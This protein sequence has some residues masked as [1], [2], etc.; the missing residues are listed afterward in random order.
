[1]GGGGGFFSDPIQSI[2]D[3]IQQDIINPVSDALSSVDHAVNNIIP[4]GWATVGAAALMAYGIYDPEL[5]TSAEEGTLT[6]TELSDAG[7][8]AETVAN[9]V[10]QA[11]QDAGFS[12]TAEY[13]TALSNGFTNATEYANATSA[14]FTNASEYA[15]ATLNGFTNA[16]EYN[17]ATTAGFT[18]AGTFQ[19]AQGLGYSTAA[20]YTAGQAGGFANAAE[21]TT[22]T[23]QGFTD[24][25]TYNT[26]NSLGYTSA[27]E[28]AAG[29]AGGFENAAQYTEAT[30]HGFNTLE[31]YQQAATNAGFSNTATYNTAL[32]AGFTDAPTYETA[33]NL[34]Y[35]TASDYS[36]GQLG[37]YANAN[38]WTTA[39]NLGYADNAQYQ[40]GLKGGFANADEMMTAMTNAGFSDPVTFGNAIDAGFTPGAGATAA[41]YLTSLQ[42]GL[43]DYG[44]YAAAVAA[45][46]IIPGLLH[47]VQPGTTGGGYAGE[48]AWQWGSA[49]ATNYPG[50]NPGLLEGQVTP[51]YTNNTSPDQAQYYWGLHQPLEGTQN[52][53][54]QW[55]TVP[56]APATPWGT[57]TSA[58]GGTEHLDIPQFVQNTIESPQYQ[59]GF[60]HPANQPVNPV[61]APAYIPPAPQQITGE[62]IPIAP[63][64]PTF[65]GP[66]QSPFQY[67][68]EELETETGLAGGAPQGIPGH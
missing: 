11:A 4:G 66:A 64:A 23:G 8:N 67:I 52:I 46:L 19:A 59:S 12:S 35:K 17:A 32:N 22:A 60:G 9:G 5:L 63:I 68:P 6:T 2:G 16:A 14:G 57:A 30:G 36:A 13:N 48:S 33:T 31:G 18:D 44:Q 55:N 1:M 29:Q 41:D 39:S 50:A 61:Q 10:S 45:G 21:Y 20:E 62:Q 43:S 54:Q 65:G 25:A 40:V 7:Y 58:V 27:N 53:G 38:D 42:A 28:F 51:Y 3:F 47:P 34:G 49:P 26:A 15:N 24:A 37:G 56:T